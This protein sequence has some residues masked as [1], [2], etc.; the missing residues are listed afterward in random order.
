MQIQCSHIMQFVVDRSRENFKI[1]QSIADRSQQ[2]RPFLKPQIKLIFKI[3]DEPSE[4]LP[5]KKWLPKIR[6][7][8][9]FCDEGDWA[10]SGIL[11]KIAIVFFSPVYLFCMWTIPVLPLDRKLYDEKW[12][13]PLAMIQAFLIPTTV[14]CNFSSCFSS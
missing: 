4:E 14:S 9:R 2:N 1:M 8:F 12:N 7:C 10:E 3:Q 13:K 5:L 11:G 6:E